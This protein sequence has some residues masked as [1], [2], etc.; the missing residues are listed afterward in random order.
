VYKIHLK[1]LRKNSIYKI[2]SSS[3]LQG[4]DYIEEGMI[5]RVLGHLHHLNLVLLD[6]SQGR[7]RLE[8]TWTKLLPVGD[9]SA[10]A[11]HKYMF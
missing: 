5:E 8:G 3:G 2:A 11:S 9:L 7:F 4:R 6:K 10:C 1:K